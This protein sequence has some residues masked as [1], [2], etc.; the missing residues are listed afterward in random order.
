MSVD[1]ETPLGFATF[2]ACSTNFKKIYIAGTYN[3][4]SMLKQLPTQ[5]STWMVVD[6][7]VF[8]VKAPAGYNDFTKGVKNVL[9]G[10]RAGTTELFR[11]ASVK[12][13]DSITL[14]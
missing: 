2:L 13:I 14:N 12:S 4:S 10:G 5:Q 1:L 6:E 11:N 7:D 8:S 3:L 9:V